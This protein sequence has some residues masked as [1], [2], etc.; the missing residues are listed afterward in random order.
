MQNKKADGMQLWHAVDPTYNGENENACAI[1]VAK[2]P[3]TTVS[4]AYIKRQLQSTLAGK[5]PSDYA[6]GLDTNE[7]RFKGYVG[8]HGLPEEGRAALG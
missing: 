4:Q 2:C 5:P 3:S 8:H 7:T 1:Y 6:S